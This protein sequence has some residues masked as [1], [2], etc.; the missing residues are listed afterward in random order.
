MAIGVLPRM[1]RVENVG[2][3]K[4][5]LGRTFQL[6]ELI[7]GRWKKKNIAQLIKMM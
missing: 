7:L 2:R 5:P 3:L 6:D 1:V 4:S